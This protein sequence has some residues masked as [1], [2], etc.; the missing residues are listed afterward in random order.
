MRAV[1]EDAKVLIVQVQVWDCCGHPKI[2][3]L[4]LI[5]LAIK[6]NFSILW[7]KATISNTSVITLDTDVDGLLSATLTPRFFFPMLEFPIGLGAPERTFGVDAPPFCP[8]GF[9]NDSVAPVDVDGP[10]LPT[11][12]SRAPIPACGRALYY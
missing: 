11:G 7:I 6:D 3:E 8:V 5:F 2:C 9:L 1:L 10:K 4:S 12:G